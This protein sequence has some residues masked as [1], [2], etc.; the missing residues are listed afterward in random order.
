VISPREIFG[1][2]YI[3]I[4]QEGK[5]KISSCCG[6]SDQKFSFNQRLEIIFLSPWRGFVTFQRDLA[7]KLQGLSGGG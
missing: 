3:S 5:I 6:N 1:A 2:Y 4:E 7:L